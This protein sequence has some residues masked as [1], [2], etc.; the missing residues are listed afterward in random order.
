MRQ[1]GRILIL[2]LA[3][4]LAGCAATYSVTPP[5]LTQGAPRAPVAVLDHGRHSSMVIG[6]A[7]GRMIRY[8]YGHWRWYAE[9]DTSAG[10]GLAALFAESPAALGRRVLPGPLTTDALRRQVLVG[11][12]EV[13]LLDVDRAAADRLVARLEA[14]FEAGRDRQLYNGLVDLDFVPDPVPYSQAHSSNRVVAGWLREMG[15]E[16]EGDGFVADWRLRR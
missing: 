6:I 10:Q 2:I 13:L 3:G 12:V 15:A 5:A 16:V 7:D 11:Y 8:A 14:I 9:N 4:A 1:L